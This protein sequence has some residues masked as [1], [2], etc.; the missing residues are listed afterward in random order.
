MSDG[1]DTLASSSAEET[2]QEQL[3]AYIDILGF[4]DATRNASAS[5]RTQIISLL[6][7][8]AAIRG[9]YFAR[10]RQLESGRQFQMRPAVSAFSD[11]I[12]I[13]FPLR[14]LREEQGDEFAPL[15]F[16]GRWVSYIAW[17]ALAMGQLIRGGVTIGHLFHADGVV[18]GPA[19]IDAYELET[20]VANYPRVVLSNTVITRAG[21][22]SADFCRF[23]DQDGL[24]CLHYMR[25]AILRNE[26]G[27]GDINQDVKP[28]VTQ[29]RQLIG[30][31]I[32]AFQAAGDLRRLSKWQWMSSYFERTIAQTPPQLLAMEAS[33]PTNQT[34]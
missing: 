30:R 1:K 12:V 13:S 32:A 4:N 8:L 3:V 21:L 20:R 7:S 18:Y 17:R 6:K 29:I 19:L 22:Q 28:W 16:L 2:D 34:I 23:V 11:N 10:S 24:S 31:N 15:F 25:D 5:D 33:K 27:G 14:D 26:I 9:D